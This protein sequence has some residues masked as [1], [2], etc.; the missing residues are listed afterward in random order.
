MPKKYPTDLKNQ[1][2]RLM[3]AGHTNAEL[4]REYGVHTDT[5]S[6]WR[7][8]EGL[9]PSGGG[10]NPY[11]EEQLETVIDL[12]KNEVTIGEISNLTGVSNSKIHK[13]YNQELQKDES[14]PEL[15]RGVARRTKYTD[16]Q[17]IGLALLNPG[18]G[19]N[20]FIHFLGISNQY[21]FDLFSDF[22]EFYD[23]D[24]YQHLQD[25]S[26]H[27]MVKESEYM[28]V[29]GSRRL[30]KGYGGGTGPRLRRSKKGT[31]NYLPLPPR[32]FIFGDIERNDSR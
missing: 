25:T 22:K 29:T 7:G 28:A 17:L 15:R 19:Y 18:Y 13:L 12:I 2:I 1:L 5:L 10:K 3:A 21:L 23:E 6:Y 24:L 26:N 20:R 9:P 27:T 31:H 30:P 4:S 16:E 8:N 11:S 32:D 14:L